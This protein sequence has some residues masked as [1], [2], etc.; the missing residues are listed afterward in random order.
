VLLKRRAEGDYTP[1]DFPKRFP[2]FSGATVRAGAPALSPLKLFEGW[3]K[4]RQPAQSTI[5]R[6]RPTFADLERTF[7]GPNAQSL[8]ED[9][10]QA[11]SK[12][13]ITPNRSASTVREFDVNAGRTIYAWAKSER[14]IADNPF[15]AVHVT[16]PR[17][18]K[19]RETDAFTVEETRT[20]L[21]AASDVKEADTALPGRSVG[22]LGYVRTQVRASAR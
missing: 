9:T 11:W 21:R 6:W 18:I 19:H 7:A 1:D 13:R 14:L 16:V 15:K 22:C 17:R 2:K 5:S 10:A 12:A 8:T 4:A 3:V 20:I